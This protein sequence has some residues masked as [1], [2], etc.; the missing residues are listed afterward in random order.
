MVDTTKTRAELTT[1]A[2][3]LLGILESG[4][5]LEGADSARIDINIDPLILQLA[6]DGV[7]EIFDTENIPSEYFYSLTVLLAN[8]CGPGF[9]IP[10]S[11]DTK[12]LHEGM[13]RRTASSGPSYGTLPL[14]FF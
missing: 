4:Q 12:D 13:L 8:N 7:V 11:K 5:T 6:Q 9:G 14:D 10:Y 3:F 1:E 2:A